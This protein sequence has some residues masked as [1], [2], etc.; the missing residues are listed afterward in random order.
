MRSRNVQF[1]ANKVRPLT[2]IYPFFDSKDVSKYCVPKLLEIAMTSGVFQVGETVFG[3][4]EGTGLGNKGSKTPAIRFRVAQSNHK[5]GPF[6]APTQVYRNNPYLSQVSPTAVETFLGTPGQVQVP[7]QGN[8][9]PETYSSTSTVLNVDTYA[10]SLQAQGEYFGYVAKDMVLVGQTS[11]AQATVSNLRLMSDLGSSLI[12]SFYIP[13]PNIGGNP[14][15]ETGDKTFT[16]VDNE[17]NDQN[18]AST[19]GEQKY[20]AKGT[21]ET[22]QEQIISVRNAEISI[23]HETDVFRARRELIGS[24]RSQQVM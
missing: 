12:G 11:G 3:K 5:E 14:K 24:E 22:V 6:N 4:M 20:T 13:N 21:L 9:L 2:R 15:F 7:G 10:L 16:L 1:V 23:K 8:V 19:I 17:D 18:A